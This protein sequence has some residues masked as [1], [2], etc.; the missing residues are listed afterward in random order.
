MIEAVGLFDYASQIPLSQPRAKRSLQLIGANKEKHVA[1]CLYVHVILYV[2]FV[3][4][5][6]CLCH[7]S[8]VCTACVG[9]IPG[10]HVWTAIQLLC[11]SVIRFQSLPCIWLSCC[12]G[13]APWGNV[14]IPCWP[15][16]TGFTA[17]SVSGET[18]AR[19]PFSLAISNS[20]DV[21]KCS[22]FCIKSLIQF[23]PLI[24]F[25]ILGLSLAFCYTV[26][27][28]VNNLLQN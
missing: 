5:Y 6:L 21:T 17:L 20:R 19:G 18:A 1:V 24:S 15:Q 26:V 13:G 2:C 10:V 14:I 28:V 8:S 27:T 12:G 23:S 22:E 11:A 7:I 3:P 9:V 25:W 16:S 4:L